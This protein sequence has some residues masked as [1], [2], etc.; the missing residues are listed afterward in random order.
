MIDLD[1][2]INVKA[3]R[4]WITHEIINKMDE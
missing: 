1:G 3:R 4:P 2:K